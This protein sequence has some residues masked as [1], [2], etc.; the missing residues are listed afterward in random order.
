MLRCPLYSTILRPS[1]LLIKNCAC[2]KDEEYCKWRAAVSKAAIPPLPDTVVAV[3]C[4]SAH[5][6]G[7]HTL[8]RRP[9]WKG[10][11]QRRREDIDKYHKRIR[12]VFTFRKHDVPEHLRMPDLFK[13][14][15]TSPAKKGVHFRP[16]FG[17]YCQRSSLHCTHCVAYPHVRTNMQCCLSDYRS[18]ATMPDCNMCRHARAGKEAKSAATTQ[19]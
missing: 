14:G 2:C 8:V 9:E 15:C 12:E 16:G 1:L 19:L 6:T 17:K 5:L 11:A 3:T 4:V 7:G 10:Y 18:S 13:E